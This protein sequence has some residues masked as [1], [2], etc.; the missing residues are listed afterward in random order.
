VRAAA[1]AP[2]GVQ[3]AHWLDVAARVDDILDPAG[4]GAPPR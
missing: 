1:S 2:A 4:R 3:R